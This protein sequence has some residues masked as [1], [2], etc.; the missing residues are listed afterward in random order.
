MDPLL[1]PSALL[2][3]YHVSPVLAGYISALSPLV[4][5]VFAPIAGLIL[6]RWGRQLYVLLMAN[7]VTIVA[8][9]LLLQVREEVS[10]G[11]QGG[12]VRRGDGKAT[13][14]RGGVVYPES[15]GEGKRS[16]VEKVKSY[17]GGVGMETFGGRGSR[18]NMK[19]E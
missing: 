4:V 11:G 8:Y 12:Y 17:G 14:R 19:Q 1:G 10:R 5:V 3:N 7:V 6:D 9:V 15:G 16:W 2:Q 18:Q 13:S